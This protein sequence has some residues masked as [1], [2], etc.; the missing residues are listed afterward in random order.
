M[1]A[2]SLPP[3]RLGTV[4][5]AV[6]AGVLFATASSTSRGTELRPERAGLRDVVREA[7]KDTANLAK[8]VD[9]L[10]AAVDRNVQAVGAPAAPNPTPQGQDEMGRSPLEG[11]GLRV[12]LSDAPTSFV[13]GD[14][15]DIN[16]LLVHQQDIEAVMNALWFAGA[17]G[18]AVGGKRLS[19]TSAVRCVG[20]TVRIDGTVMSPPYTIEAVGEPS[21][22]RAALENSPS[23]ATYRAYANK[24]SLGYQVNSSDA[25]RLPRYTEL[26][27]LH[28]A[29]PLLNGNERR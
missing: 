15:V 21:T 10:S 2:F 8:D 12:T 26:S 20:N 17:K 22:L 19:S 24:Y 5:V 7:Q 29:R 4:A 18:M 1:P 14:G 28:Y 23:V 11:P 13:P 3:A 25:L 6:L 27:G 9:E 16:H